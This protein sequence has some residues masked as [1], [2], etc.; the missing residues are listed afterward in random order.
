MKPLTDILPPAVKLQRLIGV[1]TRRLRLTNAVKGWGWGM[2]AGLSTLCAVAV[3]SRS[4]PFWTSVEVRRYALWFLI[5]GSLFGALLGTLWPVPM[6]KRLRLF[7]LRLALADR[8]TTA[9]ELEQGRITAPLQLTQL[10]LEE[11]VHKARE[12]DIK[13]AFPTRPARHSI[14]SAFALTLLLIP[15]LFLPNPQDAVLA[16][17]AAEAQFVSQAVEKLTSSWNALSKH[18]DLTPDERAATLVVLEKAIAVLENRQN[19]LGDK[20]AAL[21]EAEYQLAQMRTSED[22]TIAQQIAGIPPLSDDSA[23][24]DNSVVQRISEAL[25]RGDLGAAATYLSNLAQAEF[26]QQL[27]QS[28]VQALADMMSQLAAALREQQPEA[29]SALDAATQAIAEGNSSTARE[30]MRNAGEALSD[31]AQAQAF[32]SALQQAQA[33]L[34]QAQ[35]SLRQ[36][37]GQVLDSGMG[38]PRSSK[39]VSGAGAGQ[40]GSSNEDGAGEGTGSGADGDGEHAGSASTSVDTEIER[41]TAIGGEVTLPRTSTEGAPLPV[42]GSPNESRV[43]YQE[44]YAEYADAA[45]A[46]LSRRT[47]PP[48]LRDYIRDYFSSLE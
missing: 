7:D 33:G 26:R 46:A 1:L 35:Q 9:W 42:P 27:T 10:Q 22:V 31:L 29:A 45:E 34:Q 14:L 48:L 2:V 6:I 13:L 16:E 43:P 4:V 38:Q 41:L 23:L 36:A 3:T 44:V 21:I 20:Q 17:R 18:A 25:S 30:G 5:G 12:A 28:E 8:L 32:D 47:Y 19:N 11:A 15:A 40:S 37:A 39:P 24:P